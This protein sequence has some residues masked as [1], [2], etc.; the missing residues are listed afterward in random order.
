[1]KHELPRLPYA[2]DALEPH[3]SAETLEY[4]W[5]KHHRKY[6]ETLNELVRGTE[7]EDKP[8]DE[9]VGAAGEGKLR[10]NAAQAWNHDFYWKCLAPD[11]GSKP[12]GA[13]AAAIESSYGSFDAFREKF[14]SAGKALFGSG[15]VWLVHTGD[16]VVTIDATPN[17]ENPLMSGRIALL[18][19]DVWEHAY[20][21]DYRNERGRY[22]DAFWKLVNW[23]FVASRLG[24]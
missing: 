8:L 3:L 18:T 14:D 4:H 24:I 22:L 11:G 20:Y 16:G 17:A 13:L 2:M 1:M 9:I 19:S 10:N 23:D 12:V 6:V 7:F 21:I 5:G 15:W